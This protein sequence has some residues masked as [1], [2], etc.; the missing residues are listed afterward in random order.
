MQ[1]V[2]SSGCLYLSTGFQYSKLFGCGMCMM[3]AVNMQ[4]K[5]EVCHIYNILYDL[6]VNCS[7]VYNSTVCRCLMYHT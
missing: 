2:A 7:L 4:K 6:E 3:V 5:K 1:H